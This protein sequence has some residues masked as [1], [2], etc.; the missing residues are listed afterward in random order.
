MTDGAGID[1]DDAFENSAYVPGSDALAAKWAS[2]AGAARAVWAD[3]ATLGLAY[4]DDPREGMD[5]FSPESHAQGTVIF[6]HG[7]YWHRLDRSFWSHLAAGCLAHGWAVA[8]PGYPLAPG[9]R[10]S[11]ITQSVARAVRRIAADGAGPIRLVGHSAGGHLVTRMICEGV[12]PDDVVSRIGRVVSISGVHHLTPLL[13]TRMNETLRLTPAEARAESPTALVPQA[14]VPLTIWTG[15][16][17]RPEFLR[18]ARMLAEAWEA[19]GAKIDTV[20]AVGHNHFSVIEPLADAGSA[21][22][23]AVLS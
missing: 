15:A 21:L 5:V 23:R 18:Q 14:N 16:R 12:L 2:A 4:G 22:T 11:A 8:M 6:V 9:A 19:K 13:L 3:R 20:F 10:L 17:E 7:G 1:W